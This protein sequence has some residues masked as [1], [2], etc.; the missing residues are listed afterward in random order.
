M[1]RKLGLQRNRRGRFCGKKLTSIESDLLVSEVTGRV[2][3]PDVI[4]DRLGPHSK[5]PVAD[6]QILALGAAPLEQRLAVL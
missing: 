2:G 6:V 3:S 4:V 1:R 5:V